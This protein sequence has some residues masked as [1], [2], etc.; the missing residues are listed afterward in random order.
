MIEVTHRQVQS[1]GMTMH[2]AEAGAEPLVVFLHAP[3]RLWALDTAG[4]PG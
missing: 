3:A 2:I 4:V 1:N